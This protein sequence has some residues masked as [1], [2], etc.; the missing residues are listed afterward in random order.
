MV[1][2]GCNFDLNALNDVDWAGS[3]DDGK[4]TSG[5]AFFPGKRL[6]SWTSNKK[7]YISQSKIVVEYVAKIV[8]NSNLV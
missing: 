4:S 5:G 8:N 2:K 7:K 1:Q 6:V 3:V